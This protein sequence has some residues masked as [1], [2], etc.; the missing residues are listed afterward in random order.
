[1]AST[2]P[3][4]DPV[5]QAVGSVEDALLLAGSIVAAASVALKPNT[6]L[7]IIGLLTA[8]IGKA[9]PSLS[10]SLYRN[11]LTVSSNLWPDWKK[12]VVLLIGDVLLLVFAFVGVVL[13]VYSYDPRYVFLAM[14]IGFG[15]KGAFAIAGMVVPQDQGVGTTSLKEDSYFLAFAAAAIPMLV[16]LP[17]L[18]TAS[19]LAIVAAAAGKTLIPQGPTPSSSNASKSSPSGTVMIDG[20]IKWGSPDKDGSVHVTGTVK[21]AGKDS[22]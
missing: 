20:T 15:L 5:Q 4:E 6:T 12:N 19:A 3:K 1:M 11:Y 10:L 9:V 7:V 18:P 22:S 16:F 2:K 14:A 21:M 17:S 8:M 13:A